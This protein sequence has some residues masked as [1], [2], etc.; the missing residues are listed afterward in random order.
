MDKASTIEAH[1]FLTSARAREIWK[2]N[3]AEIMESE[4]QI[5]IFRRLCYEQIPD[6]SNIDEFYKPGIDKVIEN[7]KRELMRG[8]PKE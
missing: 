3:E 8:R 5:E 6:Y 2:E 7:A 4:K 1:R